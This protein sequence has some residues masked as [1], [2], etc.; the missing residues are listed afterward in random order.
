MVPLP[1][2]LISVM[3]TLMHSIFPESESE[4]TNQSFISTQFRSFFMWEK[5][6]KSLSK[7]LYEKH[8]NIVN[9]KLCQGNKPHAIRHTV[10]FNLHFSSKGTVEHL[11]LRLTLDKSNNSGLPLY[12]DLRILILSLTRGKMCLL[13]LSLYRN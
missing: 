8:T 2:I 4:H 11:I 12:M 13:G 5:Q 1:Y 6:G 7:F 3:F 10:C 9:W